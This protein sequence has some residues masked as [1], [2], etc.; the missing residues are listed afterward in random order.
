MNE[1]DGFLLECMFVVRLS[2]H[3]NSRITQPAN[4]DEGLNIALRMAWMLVINVI[5]LYMKGIL[6]K[7]GY[8]SL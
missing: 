2:L 3:Q 5:F 6:C 7:S 8:M 4:A 1:I